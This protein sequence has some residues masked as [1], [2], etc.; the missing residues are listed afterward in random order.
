VFE[1]NIDFQMAPFDKKVTNLDEIVL[2]DKKKEELKFSEVLSNRSLR[3][4]KIGELES[5]MDL[6]YFIIQNGFE[7]R[8]EIGKFEIYSRRPPL[9]GRPPAT[10]LVLINDRQIY[11]YDELEFMRMSDIDEVYIDPFAMVGG[12]ANNEG[13]IKIYTKIQTTNYTKGQKDTSFFIKGAFSPIVIF[14]DPDF[15]ATQNRGFD[16][17]GAIGWSSDLRCNNQ[18]D[19]IFEFIDL[20]KS[21]YK[22]ILEGI[23]NEG[24]LIHEEKIIE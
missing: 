12:G 5:N 6:V 20:K 3:G 15:N 11:R 1:K 9:S 2:K 23:T 19:F 16:N 22:I 8:R 17:F 14:K 4:I 7:V 24:K 10:P 21:K 18:G 13:I